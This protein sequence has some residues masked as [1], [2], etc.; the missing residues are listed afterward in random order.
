MSL[1]KI[2]LKLDNILAKAKKKESS[3]SNNSKNNQI[4]KE[5]LIEINELLERVITRLERK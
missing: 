2:I 4:P 5:L 3:S 1:D